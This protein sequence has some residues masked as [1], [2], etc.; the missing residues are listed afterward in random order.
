MKLPHWLKKKR[1]YIP[2]IIIVVVAGVALTN[3]KPVEP[4]TLGEQITKVDTIAVAPQSTIES[5]I[6]LKGTIYPRE[7]TR[8]RSLVS[9]DVQYLLPLGT[10]VTAGDQVAVLTDSRITESYFAAL[11]TYT[12]SERSVGETKALNVE[13]LN[14]AELAVASAESSYVIA[15]D[16]VTTTKELNAQSLVSAQDSARISYQT[17]YNT[18][19][20]V[21][22]YWSDG[23]LVDFILEDAQ[24]SDQELLKEG[25]DQFNSL[26][27]TFNTIAPKPQGDVAN[28]ISALELTLDEVKDFNDTVLRILNHTIA[29]DAYGYSEATIAGY[30]QKATVYVSQLNGV[31]A[32][33]RGARN[34]LVNTEIAN[35][36]KMLAAENQLKQAHI[37]LDNAK[38]TRE[39]AK[40]QAEIREI[41]A[42]SQLA[43]AQT[44]L[45]AARSQYNALAI[46]A[47]FSGVVIA[48]R[49]SEGDQVS[50][51]QELVE[52]G[53]IEGVEIELAI[54]DAQA[55][56][57]H[58]GQTV[59][60]TDDING[61]IT[62]ISPTA[63]LSSGKVYF[64]VA[65]DNVGGALTAGDVATIRIPLVVEQEPAIVL[66]LSVVTIGQSETYVMVV[67]QGLVTKRP[68]TLGDTVN[69]MVVVAEGLNEGDVVIVKNGDFL[70]FGDRVEI[71]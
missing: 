62:E 32:S 13:S 64:T 22:R 38:A 34:A 47:P 33:V 16:N 27:V 9:A 41:G 12:D 58:V 26:K 57:L 3:N 59:A 42:N 23:T 65:A 53:Q 66:P 15:E 18:M 25:I 69:N 55:S 51:G 11:Q 17:A 35:R 61:T 63:S 56:L 8:M 68:V 4:E 7:Y 40:R 36:S 30:K 39:S 44:Q 31:N 67:E 49:V 71:K 52:L 1:F 28:A 46:T 48:H 54:D 21:L 29:N 10:R 24:T 6:E 2:A 70:D 45:A 5:Y 20:E 50:P 43:G 37:Q 14:Q 19:E 60:V